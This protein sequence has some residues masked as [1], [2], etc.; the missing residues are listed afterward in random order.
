MSGIPGKPGNVREF[1]S[2]QRNV[3][4]FT[5]SQENVREK[6]L[7]EKSCLRLFILSC[8][9]CVHTGINYYV[10]YVLNIKYI[11]SDHA[12]LHSYPTTDS[13]TSIGMI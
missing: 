1:D 13:N 11:V 4:D 9:F 5:K 3:R 2:C 12:L 8:I 7:S 6:I 10:S